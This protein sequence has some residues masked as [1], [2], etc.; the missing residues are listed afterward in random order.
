M[1]NQR[2]NFLIFCVDQMS[3][4]SLGCHGNPD[5]RTPR[6]DRLASE[7]VSFRRGYCNNSVCMPSRSTMITGLTPRQ[8]GCLTNGTSLPARIPTITQ[9]LVDAGYRT[10][11]VGKLHYQPFNAPPPSE[12][13]LDDPFGSWESRRGWEAGQITALP[14]PYYGFQH[15]DYVGG[16]VHYNFGD[17]ANWLAAEH[18]GTHGL[19][20]KERAYERGAESWKLDLP[21]ALHYN[22]WIAQRA[23]DG[24]SRADGR[25]FFLFCSFPDPHHPFAAC[26]PFSEMYD[27]ANLTLNPT[28]DEREEPCAWMEGLYR[29]SPDFSE[30]DL[31][32]DMA[33]TYGMIT[34]LDTCI[35]RVLD[36]LAVQGLAQN[37]VVVMLADHGE[38]LGSHH[39]LYKSTWPWEELLRVPFIW[40]DPRG[41]SSGVDGTPVGLLDLAPTILDY[42]GVPQ[43]VLSTRQPEAQADWPG[44]PGRSLRPLLSDG[45]PLPPR[46][47]LAE[48]DE[49]YRPGPMV[50]RRTIIDGNWKL[51]LFG[52]Q[53]EGMLYNL[54]DD[55]HETRNL[56]A[57]PSRADVRASLTASL[58]DGLICSDPYY[59]PRISGA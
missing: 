35:G 37:T 33:Q 8:H 38:Y 30:A 46:P 57:D 36:G 31:R 5:V 18:P 56:W 21:E 15:V 58:L 55:P 48:F 22:N 45:E 13:M 52:G 9:A 40:R 25:P 54:A 42:A 50:R 41:L 34:H 26:R 17:Y 29:P 10:H 47:V 28:W 2:P 14:L 32:A 1:S 16:H 11:A 27:P 53:S 7:G 44:L 20:A 39:L 3:S 6:L 4:F 43:D 24:L 51:T 49:D 12:G 23:I 19:Y 59:G